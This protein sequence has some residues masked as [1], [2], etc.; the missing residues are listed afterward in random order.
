MRSDTFETIGRT[1]WVWEPVAEV[2]GSHALKEYHSPQQ[3]NRDRWASSGKTDFRFQFKTE[4]RYDGFRT[5]PHT[6][7]TS[8]SCSPSKLISMNA[9]IG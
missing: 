4:T 9:M 2:V 3:N 7:P 1:G 5:T 6:G 8:L